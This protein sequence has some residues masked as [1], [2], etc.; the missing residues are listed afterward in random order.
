MRV[1]SSLKFPSQSPMYLNFSA[2]VITS[3]SYTRD[4]CKQLPSRGH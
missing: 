2:S 1:K 3:A 4:V